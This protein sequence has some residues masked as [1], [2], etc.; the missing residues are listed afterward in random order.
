MPVDK[1]E[2]K[3]DLITQ[4]MADNALDNLLDCGY[5]FPAHPPDEIADDLVM[6]YELFE[7]AVPSQLIGFVVRWLDKHPGLE[8]RSQDAAAVDR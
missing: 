7:D 5:E 4:Q 2:V 6:L 1:D 8:E 3:M